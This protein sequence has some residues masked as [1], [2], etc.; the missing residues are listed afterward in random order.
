M[1]ARWLSPLLLAL[2]GGCQST[3][4][5]EGRAAYEAYPPGEPQRCLAVRQIRTVEP[6]GDH[7]LLFYVGNGD[8][9]RNRLARP[10]PGMRRDQTLMY[11]PRASQLCASDVVWQ[12]EN[13]G[14]GFRRGG[15]CVLGEFDYLTEDQAEAVKAFR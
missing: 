8:V 13:V 3:T 7:S 5:E 10:C 2:V 1:N 9:W 15:A 4:S 6:V 12:L 11:E 14:F